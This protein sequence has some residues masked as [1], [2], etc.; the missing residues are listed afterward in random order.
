V[1]LHA[2]NFIQGAS[3]RGVVIR[4]ATFEFGTWAEADYFHDAS[5]GKID[6]NSNTDDPDTTDVNGFFS[7]AVKI[8][9]IEII[10]RAEGEH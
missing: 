9:R 8:G 5:I 3:Q 2:G 6:N 1:Y 7:P 10:N 4:N